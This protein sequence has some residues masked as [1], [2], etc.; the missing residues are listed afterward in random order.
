MTPTAPGIPDDRSRLA[1]FLSGSG[2]TLTNLHERITAGQLDASIV[3]VV[4]SRE[5]PGV[6]RARAF[7]YTPEVIPSVFTPEALLEHLRAHNAGLLVLAGYLK[8]VPVPPELR[9]RIVNIHPA[10]L[11]G[12]GTGGRFGGK[13]LYGMR[14]H[15][16]VLEAGEAESGCTV[17]FCSD[18]YDAGPVILRKSCPVLPGDTPESLAARVFQL[19]LEALPEALQLVIA[20]SRTSP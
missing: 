9:D 16:A 1:V 19:E 11:P 4:A 7:G 3:D 8:K 20:G 13:G 6:E 2:R 17:H 18:Q 15:K 5:C 14:V 12:D 10:L